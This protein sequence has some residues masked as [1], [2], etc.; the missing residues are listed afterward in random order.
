ML[1]SPTAAVISDPV[2]GPTTGWGFGSVS[3]LSNL[4]DSAD[5]EFFNS[6]KMDCS[7]LSAWRGDDGVGPAALCPI[8]GSK[9]SDASSPIC[10]LVLRA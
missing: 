2:E 10:R 5:M 9:M 8:D 6:S 4:V 7:P 1:A 3:N